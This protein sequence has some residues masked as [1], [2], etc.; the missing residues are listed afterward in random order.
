MMQS[1]SSLWFANALLPGG[2]QAGVRITVTQGRIDRVATD[3]PATNDDER[4]AAGI[5]GASSVHSHAFQR[6]LAGLTEQHRGSDNFWSWRDRMYTLVQKLTP[7]HIE[8]ITALTYLEMLECGIT[9]VGEFHYLH[10]AP[11]GMPYAHIAE[12]AERVASAASET[13]IGLTLLPVLYAHSGVNGKPPTEQQRRFVNSIDSFANLLDASRTAVARLRF[14]NV[15]VAAHSLRA[16]TPEELGELLPL[17][18]RGPIH[19]HVA[20]QLEEV[21][22]WQEFAGCRPVEWLIDHAPV[23]ERWCLVHATHVSESES[24][25]LAAN[26][27]VVG[28]CPITEANLGDGIFPA[29]EFV[30]NGGR[31]GIGTD[32][33]VLINF[34]EELRLLEYGQRLVQRERNVIRGAQETSTGRT[35]F[36]RALEGGAQALD[37]H[38]GSLS[39]GFIADI[40]SLSIDHP[41]MLCREGDALLD[42]WIFAGANAIDCVWS[43]GEKVVSDGRHRLRE[44]VAGRYATVIRTL[45]D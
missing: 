14:A 24:R 9:R 18:D 7:E 8:A 35:L 10:H 11:G 38:T 42:S 27:A 43:A 32:S 31:F 17:A 23:N 1:H 39:E 25:R 4:H 36:E 30:A 40:V 3:V 19:I 34:A 13:G 16:V 12:H 33:N 26:D 6:V 5:P 22:Q 21:R 45:L 28:L 15:G 37:C 20:E 44:Q 2:W 29:R 41:S